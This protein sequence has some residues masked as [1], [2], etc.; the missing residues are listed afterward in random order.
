MEP[1][2]ASLVRNPDAFFWLETLRKRDD[3]AYGH[4]INC[5]AFAAFGRRTRFPEMVLHDLATGGMLLD[6]G[7]TRVPAELLQREGRSAPRT[8]RSVRGMS[9][10]D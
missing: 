3:Y 7:M 6:I 4:A 5:W 8:T 2:V 9:R 1:V 10:K